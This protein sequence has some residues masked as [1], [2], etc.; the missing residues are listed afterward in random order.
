MSELHTQL[1]LRHGKNPPQPWT[2]VPSSN[3][4]QGTPAAAKENSMA[5]KDSSA[6][7]GTLVS[8]PARG[9]LGS[10][11]SVSPVAKRGQSTFLTF[12]VLPACMSGRLEPSPKT[13]RT[14]NPRPSSLESVTDRA[15]VLDGVVKVWFWGFMVLE[16]W[17]HFS[18]AHRNHLGS[19]AGAGVKRGQCLQEPS[20]PWRSKP[21]LKPAEGAYRVSPRPAH[22][23]SPSAV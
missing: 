22:A 3:S 16:D 6:L 4:H 8:V 23:P 19:T 10:S 9:G 18:P 21:C 7:R 12:S 15:H 1:Y 17:N 13:V 5:L 20:S 11:P 14:G 2:N